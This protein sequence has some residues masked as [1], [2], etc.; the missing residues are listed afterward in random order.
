MGAPPGECVAGA[1]LLS[2]AQSQHIVPQV[3][4]RIRPQFCRRAD[5]IRWHNRSASWLLSVCASG[6]RKRNEAW[7]PGSFRLP[8]FTRLWALETRSG[9]AS[10]KLQLRRPIRQRVFVAVRAVEQQHPLVLADQA[11]ASAPCAMP[12]STAPPSGQNRKPSSCAASSTACRIASSDTAIAAPPLS[13]TARRIRKSPTALGTRIPVAT[14]A[15]MLPPLGELVALLK[16]TNHRRAAFGLDRIHPRPL[17]ADEPDRLQ[18]VERLPHA[19]EAG[20]A[21]GRIEDRVR[22][23][24]AELLGKLETHH[25][26]A[27][28]AIRLLQGR[29]VEPQSLAPRPCRP[30]PRIRRSGRRRHRPAR[31]RRRSR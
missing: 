21:A 1:L 30:A 13:R 26:L 16:R 29:A 6:S 25:L 5:I 31:R 11:L 22:Q 4:P 12:A 2:R 19:D 15:G 10:V 14:V 8:G 9:L 24:P 18:L 3:Y 20:T 7:S 23:L 27:L 17:G 28:E